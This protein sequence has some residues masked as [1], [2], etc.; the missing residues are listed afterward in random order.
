M[1][2]SNPEPVSIALRC[3]E[4]REQF[5]RGREM[6]Q[7]LS[8]RDEASERSACALGDR[9]TGSVGLRTEP[10]HRHGCGEDND[11]AITRRRDVEKRYFM[12]GGG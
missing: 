7:L 2:V 12:S 8:R 10:S 5:G 3:V 9:N 1:S 6:S 11:C 4:M